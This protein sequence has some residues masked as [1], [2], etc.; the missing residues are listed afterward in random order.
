MG[1]KKIEVTLTHYFKLTKTEL[2][3]EW[4]TFNPL[5]ERRY[6]EI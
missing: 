4:K 5:N 2:R 6:D 3:H 1:H